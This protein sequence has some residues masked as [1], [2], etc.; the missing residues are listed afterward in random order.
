MS[1][2]LTVTDYSTQLADHFK[3]FEVSQEE[4]KTIADA[5]QRAMQAFQ[6]MG[7]PTRKHEEWKYTNIGK[8]LRNGFEPRINR[9]AADID[10]AELEKA[11]VPGLEA[12]RIVFV[13]GCFAP[14]HSTILD[15]ELTFRSMADVESKEH[16]VVVQAMDD[17][18]NA[19][20]DP[21][22]SLNQAFW[23]D[24]ALIEV[25]DNT[26]L[27]HPI[28][29]I[30]LEKPSDQN[31]LDSVFNV[32]SVGKNTK[33]QVIQH[34]LNEA[35]S[36]ANLANHFTKVYVDVNSITEWYSLQNHM[37]E[38]L[39]L[40]NFE[41]DV[42]RDSR[43]S[44]YAITSSG[45]LIR[46]TSNIRLLGENSESRMYG[47]YQLDGTE[48]VDNRTLVDHVVPHCFSD[49]LYKGIL[50]DKSNAVF[51]G[52]IIVRPD[53]QKT[54]AFQHNPN[55][56]LSD[57]ASVYSKPQLEIFADDVKC[58]HGAT[59]GQLDEEALFYLRQRGLG[60]EDARALLIYAFANDI[61]HKI[62]VEPLRDYLAKLIQGKL[63]I[64]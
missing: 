36:E 33:V 60:Q 55:I 50:D 48:H 31:S 27:A 57:D 18:M 7:F 25:P 14:E 39:H 35:P 6:E 40:S 54:N 59:T 2:T 37:G 16:P 23:L 41:V 34:Y 22:I 8:Y 38:G 42:Q 4:P 64:H 5:R 29:L 45:T 53:A 20:K 3:V 24:G 1:Q 11:T 19:E 17:V 61:I 28:H 10:S 12:N 52:K 47:L 44:T 56:V 63:M 51:N 13:N 9:E 26:E 58:S 62:N 46:N 32:L 15:K 30:Y 49:E 43:F 21:F